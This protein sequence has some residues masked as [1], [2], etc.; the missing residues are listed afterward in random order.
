MQ[1]S[2]FGRGRFPEQEPSTSPLLAARLVWAAIPSASVV[3]SPNHFWQG[4][5]AAYPQN[6][7][8]DTSKRAELRD[9]GAF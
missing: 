2:P 7:F 4:K 8:V 3:C 1:G 5:T 6:K 9:S